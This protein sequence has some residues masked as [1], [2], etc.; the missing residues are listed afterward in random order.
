M[1]IYEHAKVSQVANF[2]GEHLN[3]VEFYKSCG[4]R[5]NKGGNKLNI[6]SVNQ[7]QDARNIS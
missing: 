4:T 7:L 5:M 3:L 6:D 1:T 2:R